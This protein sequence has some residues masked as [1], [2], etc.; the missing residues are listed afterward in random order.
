MS[1]KKINLHVN[2]KI[3]ANQCQYWNLKGKKLLYC[4]YVQITSIYKKEEQNT[5]EFHC[6]A[7]CQLLR[8]CTNHYEHQLCVT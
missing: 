6:E 2:I 3:Y 1:R 4:M 7:Y 8:V 5:F